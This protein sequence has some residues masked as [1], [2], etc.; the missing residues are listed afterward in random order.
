MLAALFRPL[1]LGRVFGIPIR[2]VP[3]ALL[4]FASPILIVANAG[5]RDL[6]PTLLLVGHLIFGLLL[7]EFGHALVAQRLGLRVVDVTI[8]PL[9]GMARIEGLS[10]R[11]G[12]EAPVAA[13]G[14]AAN[15]LLAGILYLLPAGW[16]S[17]GIGLNLVFG[18]GNLLPLYPLDGGRILR[19]WLGRRSPLVD[20]TRAA[21]AP[22][23]LLL[24]LLI[25]LGWFLDSWL[26]P[27]LLGL[28]LI[29]AA[30]GDLLRTMLA[31]GPPIYSRAEVW[32]RALG[33][34]G[35]A[36]AEVK[37]PPA[38]PPAAARAESGPIVEV[39][40]E[41]V[42]SELENFRGPLDEFFRDRS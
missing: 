30:S 2:V 32:K 5:D 36:A 10:E 33:L 25:S 3:V 28:Y 35:Y 18:L 26:V 12:L 15:L 37:E 20:A 29:S 9:V 13:A 19:A 38:P 1:P 11:P 8:W 22:T 40:A 14:P 17:A 24:I 7:H 21:I 41:P 31:L 34:G 42:A 39:E 23:W 16:W 4:L 27:V 6:T